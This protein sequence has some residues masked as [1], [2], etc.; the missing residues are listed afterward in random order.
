MCCFL[1]SLRISPSFVRV[2]CQ[3]F[4]CPIHVSTR[5]HANFTPEPS[6][7]HTGHSLLSSKPPHRHLKLG[8]RLDRQGWDVTHSAPKTVY[9]HL[10]LQASGLQL[11]HIW[12]RIQRTRRTSLSIHV[13]DQGMVARREGEDLK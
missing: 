8:H 2:Q 5:G 7:P 11:K 6:V 4:K 9:D 13:R 3:Q 1:K 12:P 10:S